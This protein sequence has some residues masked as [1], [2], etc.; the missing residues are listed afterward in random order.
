MSRLIIAVFALSQL[1]ACANKQ[2]NQ[3]ANLFEAGISRGIVDNRLHE[4]SGLVESK[5]FA[6]HLWTLND[7]GNPAEVFLLDSTA[8][9]KMTCKL[10]D[11][12]NR[13]FEDIALGKGPD[14]S[15]TYIY[16]ADIGDNQARYPVK[17][18]YR[19]AE[20]ESLDNTEVLITDFDTLQITL[21][22]GVRDSETLLIDPINNDMY[23]VSKLEDS[24]N[25]YRIA[26]PF[27]KGI[28]TAE[29][30]ATLPF[31]KIV[32]GDFSVDGKEVLLKDY[33]YVYYWKN[34]DNLSLDKLLVTKH[35]ILQY[36]GELQGEAIAWARNGSGYYTLSE[37][38]NDTLGKLLF[39]KR[40]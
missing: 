11:V 22:D 9:I 4:A 38:V 10:R 15:K 2:A 17:L 30:V 3:V 37:K 21:P 18:I 35:E 14:S 26:Y 24:V 31:H 16:V 28:I 19:F 23:I 5:Q 27:A 1:F 40:N 6:S 25:L 33:D 34:T 39:Y 29:K 20:P 7:S 8:K 32:A 36:D 12:D 13:D